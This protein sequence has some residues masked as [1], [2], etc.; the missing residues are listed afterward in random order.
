M[1]S[2][3]DLVATPADLS[4]S[5][6]SDV[7][8]AVERVRHPVKQEFLARSKDFDRLKVLLA[9]LEDES[10]RKDTELQLV[11]HQLEQTKYELAISEGTLHICFKAKAELEVQ[12]TASKDLHAGAMLGQLCLIETAEAMIEDTREELEEVRILARNAQVDYE[13]KASE[14]AAELAATK[15]KLEEVTAALRAAEEKNESL[16]S[17]IEEAESLCSL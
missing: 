17:A 5:L 7:L 8:R 4:A 10:R 12:L 14:Q 16:L 13:Q 9:A 2:P 1:S 6:F 15:V 11:C 3:Q